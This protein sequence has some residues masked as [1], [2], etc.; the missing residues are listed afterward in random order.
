MKKQIA[1]LAGSIG[2][3]LIAGTALA[4]SSGITIIGTFPTGVVSQT[5]MPSA[6]LA[7]QPSARPPAPH[8]PSL[9]PG[10]AARQSKAALVGYIAGARARLSAA[11][12]SGAS[13]QILAGVTFRRPVGAPALVALTGGPRGLAVTYVEWVVPGT[14]VHGGGPAKD[15]DA[16][17]KEHPGAAIVFALG[18]GSGDALAAIDEAADVL[19][20]DPA[21]G[22]RATPPDLYDAAAQFGLAEVVTP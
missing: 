10:R 14:F 12:Q 22:T 3:V 1:V 13:S 11:R 7:A 19:F 17:A 20:V 21:D 4:I 8:D 15:F 2:V 5:G 16:T 18:L 9:T 6:D